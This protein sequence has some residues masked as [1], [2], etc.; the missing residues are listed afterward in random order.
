MFVSKHSLPTAATNPECTC[1][2]RVSTWEFT[3]P[4]VP[5]S[6]RGEDHG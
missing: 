5:G 2:V 4:T 1:R 3:L 6:V